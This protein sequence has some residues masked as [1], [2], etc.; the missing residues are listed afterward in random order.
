MKNYRGTLN[1]QK[2]GER[3]CMIRMQWHSSKYLF[4]LCINLYGY[5]IPMLRSP[6]IDIGDE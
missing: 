4:I 3:E 2:L 6:A 5:Q 1:F